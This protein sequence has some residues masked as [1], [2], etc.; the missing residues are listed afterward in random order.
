MF[1]SIE[2]GGEGSEVRGVF[3]NFY[4][5]TQTPRAWTRQVWPIS[6]NESEVVLRYYKSSTD[7]HDIL[8]RVANEYSIA[9]L[10]DVEAQDMHVIAQA[11]R[12]IQSGALSHIH[13]QAHEF[14]LRHSF[15]SVDMMVRGFAK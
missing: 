15:E 3:P 14:M 13:L 10:F 5:D 8:D 6:V 12:G 1:G 9:L 4:V 2:T 7:Q 11:Y